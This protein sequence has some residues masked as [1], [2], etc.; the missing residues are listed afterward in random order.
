MP[1][2]KFR[3]D[4]R[5]IIEPGAAADLVVFN[6]DTIADRATWSDPHQYPAGIEAVVVNGV[7]VV[8]HGTHTAR[9][10]GRILRRIPK[11]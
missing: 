7:L 6:P 4:G 10:A 2:R 1:A 5:G 9:P 11:A 8:D 3:L